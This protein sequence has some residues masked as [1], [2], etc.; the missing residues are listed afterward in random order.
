MTLFLHIGTTKTGTT[1]IQQFLTGNRALLK[2]Q[3]Y[4]VPKFSNR[5]NHSGLAV[6]S[7]KGDI[8]ALDLR[9]SVRDET[10]REA[11][12]ET[13]K[14]RFLKTAAQTDGHVV[15]SSE[16]CFSLLIEPEEIEELASLLRLSGQDCKVVVYLRQQA[17]FLL[18][19]FSTHV[20]HGRT[21]P[22]DYPSQ[23]VID[24]KL[25]FFSILEKWGGVFGRENILARVFDRD[26]LVDGNAVKDFCQLLEMPASITE[27]AVFPDRMNES[28]DFLTIEFLRNFNYHSAQFKQK[29]LNPDR[30]NI[31]QLLQRL[32]NKKRPRMP[33]KMLLHLKEEFAESNKMLRQYYLDGSE[34]EPFNWDVKKGARRIEAITVDQ[35]FAIFARLWAL[36]MEETRSTP[37]KRRP[38][39]SGTRE[40]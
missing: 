18:S 35:A 33:R 36:K 37:D 5:D 24:T 16:H 14:A 28:L 32:S 40:G 7:R 39:Q 22:L 11:F 1:S 9:S 12:R 26:N 21:N 30:G 3:G 29:N 38:L 17:D 15:L 2:R 34:D 4:S 19:L 6:Y 13:F 23:F 25:D 27:A 31:G 8:S 20:I 10:D